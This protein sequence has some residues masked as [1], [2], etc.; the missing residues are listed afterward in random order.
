MADDQDP[1]HSALP[2]DPAVLEREIEARREHLASTVDELIVRAHP[3]AVARRGIADVKARIK[4]AARDED[5]A[6]R[7]ERVGAVAA[8]TLVVVV[9]VI[10]R[11]RRR[12]R[13]V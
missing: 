7:T 10:W 5:G 9:M 6:L 8:A 13:A 12:R 11:A 2:T 4:A 3:K 1:G